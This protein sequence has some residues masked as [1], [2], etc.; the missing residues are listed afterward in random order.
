VDLPA[1]GRQSEVIGLTVG[2]VGP[3][4]WRLVSVE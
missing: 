2:R 4:A 3:T 1:G